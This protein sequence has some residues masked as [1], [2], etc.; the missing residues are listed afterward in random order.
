MLSTGTEKGQV[1]FLKVKGMKSSDPELKFGL[2]E[3]VDDKWV[4]TSEYSKVSGSIG[5][6]SL[7]ENEY[8]G[9]KI[10]SIVVDMVDDGETYVISFGFNGLGFS[11]ISTLLSD[12]SKVDSIYEFGLGKKTTRGADGRE[13]VNNKI[14][15]T[16]NGER[17][18]W[19]VNM[20]DAPKKEKVLKNDGTVFIQNGKPVYDSTKS[21]SFWEDKLKELT[22]K[23][24]GL[25]NQPN[26]FEKALD[27]KEKAQVENSNVSN[28]EEDD[29]PF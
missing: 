26:V 23:F 3:K 17:G 25:K 4:I 28:E 20:K 10:K 29:M 13:Y 8:Q 27:K 16:V 2:Q 21:D 5:K 6:V 15:I 9:S 22:V 24:S 7:R 1:K 11:L 18:Q 19:G 12:T 14:Y